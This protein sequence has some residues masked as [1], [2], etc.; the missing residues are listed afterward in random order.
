MGHRILGIQNIPRL[1]T[2]FARLRFL[3]ERAFLGTL[4]G[5]GIPKGEGR[6]RDE[7]CDPW[8]EK[9]ERPIELRFA[10]PRNNSQ[11]KRIQEEESSVHRFLGLGTRH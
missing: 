7:A 4:A 10:M 2:L 3:K 1:G 5:L 11:T 9:V 6:K 8:R